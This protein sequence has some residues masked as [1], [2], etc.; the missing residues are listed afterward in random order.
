MPAFQV[1]EVDT[2][3]SAAAPQIALP[4]DFASVFSCE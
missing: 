4:D 1:V 3:L 2:F